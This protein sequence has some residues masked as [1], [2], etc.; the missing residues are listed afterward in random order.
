MSINQNLKNGLKKVRNRFMDSKNKGVG[1]KKLNSVF[2]DIDML[3]CEQNEFGLAKLFKR[4]Y[5]EDIRY[6]TQ[7]KMYMLFSA[8]KGVWEIDRTE[9]LERKV[10]MFLSKHCRELVG[11]IENKKVRDKWLEW[12]SKQQSNSVISGI[13]RSLRRM[14]G[15]AAV[16]DDFDKYPR[17]FCV[18]NGMLDMVTT[19]FKDFEKKCLL[20]KQAN[21]MFDQ[22]NKDTT[23]KKFL[24]SVFENDEHLYEYM[25]RAVLYAMQGDANAH[26]MFLL[27]GPT[28]R[29]GKSTLSRGLVEFFSDYAATID[30]SSLA[31]RKSNTG[32]PSPD[33]MKLKGKRMVNVP[34][35]PQAIE[36][37]V[38]FIKAITG[39]DILN[40]RA[41]YKDYE[42]FTNNAVFFLH[43]NRLPIVKDAT[44]FT[45][46]RIIV[47]PFY[48]HFG[49]HEADPDMARK[50][51]Q[52]EAMSGVLNE[53][54][55]IREKYKGVSIKEKLPDEVKKSTQEFADACDRVGHFLRTQIAR[56]ENGWIPKRELYQKYCAFMRDKEESPITSK[57]FADELANR[58][59]SITR[60]KSGYGLTGYKLKEN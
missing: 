21:V 12:L 53:V 14:K 57:M 60:R 31:K 13:L 19:E 4:L 37:D 56:K 7:E 20:T 49:I 33:V 1:S 3:E 35:I 45:S 59:Y 17:Y 26:C 36:L 47:I 41:L 18:K 6:I 2:A 23:W 8:S 52:P 9:R 43:M 44:L 51:I 50:L 58:Q 16:K 46:H 29:N 24:M 54:I 25:L 55:R 28:T 48:R 39:Q 38:A 22:N 5:G 40:S 42:E 15:I 32:G 30:Q 10:E 11:K 27:Y 34:E